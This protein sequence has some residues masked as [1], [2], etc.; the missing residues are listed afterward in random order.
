MT[1]S[2]SD[3]IETINGQVQVSC[4]DGSASVGL[5]VERDGIFG[6]TLLSVEQAEQLANALLKKTT[7][8]RRVAERTV[9]E[10][11][12]LKDLNILYR[13]LVGAYRLPVSALSDDGNAGRKGPEPA[14]P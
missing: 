14:S 9:A 3:V 8:S 6:G 11:M 1:V 7:K 10:S 2:N 12:G 5:L 13:K 4:R